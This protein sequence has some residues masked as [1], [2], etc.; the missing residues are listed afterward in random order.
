MPGGVDPLSRFVRAAFY[1]DK[2]PQPNSTEQAVAYAFAL[3]GT[4][5]FPPAQG[6]RVNPHGEYDP[7]QAWGTIWYTVRDHSSGRFYF[8]TGNCIYT[9]YLDL[10]ELDLSEDQ[11]IKAL[12]MKSDNCG[13]IS[14]LLEPCR[15][16]NAMIYLN[17]A[18]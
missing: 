15:V 12:D 3:I 13:D 1:L 10:K 7:D 5:C 9:K 18:K 14:Q 17:A 8:R 4:V 6:V 2:L 11:P 16:E